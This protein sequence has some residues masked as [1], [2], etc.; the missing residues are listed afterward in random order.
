MKNPDSSEGFEQAEGAGAE[1]SV[2]A[3]EAAAP[4]QQDVQ[5]EAGQAEPVEGEASQADSP[6]DV[7]ASEDEPELSET[8]RT[9]LELETKVSSLDEELKRARADLFNLDKEYSNYVRRAKTQAGAHRSDGER[10]VVEA[11][12]SVLDDIAAARAADQLDGPFAAIATK[13]ETT[14]GNGFGLARFGEAGEDF[15]PERHDALMAEAS[16]D[17]E[18]PTV[19][20]VLQPGYLM[21]ERVLRPAKVMVHNPE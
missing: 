10:R 13:L 1:E 16:A 5:E 21:G 19:A 3:P 12:I 7:Q 15:D 20:Q 6:A 9:I 14:L 4:D 2:P 11:L 8:D 17:V 18:V